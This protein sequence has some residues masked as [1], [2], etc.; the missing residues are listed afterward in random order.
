MGGTELQ[1]NT[2]HF[3]RQI[4]SQFCDLKRHAKQNKTEGTTNLRRAYLPLLYFLHFK[5]STE[6]TPR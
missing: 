2:E 3:T 4:S 1:V 6:S 5:T